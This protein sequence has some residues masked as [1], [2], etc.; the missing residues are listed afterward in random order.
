MQCDEIRVEVS[1]QWSFRRRD[2]WPTLPVYC[3]NGGKSEVEGLQLVVGGGEVR[4]SGGP[5]LL[6]GLLMLRSPSCAGCRRKPFEPYK[7]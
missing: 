1:I 4:S 3:S 6:W 7:S 2:I 5:G